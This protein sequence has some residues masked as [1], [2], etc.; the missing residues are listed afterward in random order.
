MNTQSENNLIKGV[1][2]VLITGDKM[3]KRVEELGKKISEDFAGKD[4]VVVGVLKGSIIFFAD[5]VRK[6]TL[7][8]TLD[9][10]SVSSYG[11]ATSSTGVV[12]VRKDISCDI[13]GKD[14]LIVEDII[15]TGLTLKYLKDM[16]VARNAK[17]VSICSA[18]DK[19]SRRDK[20]IDIK[21]EYIGFQIPDEFVVGYGLD[22]SEKYRNLSDICV[23]SAEI[24]GKN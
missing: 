11:G 14:V 18:L 20:H 19:P 17:S 23:L 3:Q 12:T 7:P 13:T 5:L 24:Y 10:I 15:D 16:F 21:V 1:K 2:E 9:F 6:I 8:I 22:Y 4:L